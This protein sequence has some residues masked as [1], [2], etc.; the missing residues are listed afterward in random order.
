[1]TA[2]AGVVAS[3]IA[4]GAC[5][6]GTGPALNPYT[7][8]AG[9]PPPSKLG[10][11]DA[12]LPMEVDLGPSF[13]IV[14]LQPSHG[15]WTGGT[16]TTIVGRG[17]SSDV[18]VW[19]GGT[20]LPAASVLASDPMHIAVVTPPGTPGPADV[21]VRNTSS[22]E[23][24]TLPAGFT[25]DAFAVMPSQGST[26]GGTRIALKGKGTQWTAASTIAV[27]GTPCNGFSFQDAT[28]VSCVTPPNSPGSVPVAV[29][30]G[31]G[32]MDLASD[33][34]TYTDS[35]DGY[36]GGLYGGALAGALTVLAF[37]AWTGAPVS[38]VAIAGSDLATAVTG[39]FGANGAAQLSGASLTGKVTVTA[40]AHCHQPVT[41]VD[42]PVDTVTV[43]LNP[44]LSPA[45]AQGE[46][47]SPGNWY[48]TDYGE[49]D[50]ELVFPSGKEFQ[51]GGWTN[52]PSPAGERQHAVAYVFTPSG[53]PAAAFGLPPESS[54]TTPQS[55]GTIG[56]EYAL[57]NLSP[58]NT[59][60]YALAGIEDDGADPPTFEP[61]VIGAASG[62]TVSPGA[63]TP[64][65][66]LQM[67]TL[68]NRTITTVPQPP[69]GS[70]SGPDR[71]VTT[72]SLALAT[73][74]Y[75]LL[76][77]G[78]QT[79]L[80]PVFGDVTFVGV[81]GLDQ[82]LAGASYALTASAVTGTGHSDP[83]S[84]VQAIQTTDAND[85]I[86]I[87]GF[88]G[89][90]TLAEPGV[91]TWSGTHVTLQESTS[92]DLAV[93]NVSSGGGLIEWQIVSPGSDLSFDLPDLT[94]VQGVDSL[95]HGPISTR[96]DV[97]RI[98][99]LDYGTLRTGQLQTS[100]WNAYAENNAS[101]SY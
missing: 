42:V 67:S 16:S 97:A 84:V 94:Q 33:A 40:A 86:T 52:V 7:D 21:K 10:S 101:G 41:Y 11:D 27:G 26:T 22:A 14:G 51:R 57:P 62:V 71:L 85:P 99:G 69:V 6:P 54:A 72:V 63:K 61:F 34:F 9:A 83:A 87:G 64:G 80:F 30:N 24:T 47:P 53:N 90:P 65:V 4:A 44:T 45:C 91:A 82:S 95:V 32:S 66:Y 46:P 28:D 29:T 89:V 55:A 77:Q 58:G 8:D 18:T 74:G 23:E 37:D 68:L 76:P 12:A 13:A 93:V 1:M 17:F 31:D 60:L 43:Y 19:I 88:L 5:L 25:Y 3:V 39:V 38:G 78:T 98:S 79:T 36:R 100:A 15:P 35:P 81:P 50:G 59:N 2:L 49:I 48:P 70:P 20:Q 92:P 75:A 96:Y 73:G 56:Y